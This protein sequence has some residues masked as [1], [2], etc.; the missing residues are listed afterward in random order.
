MLLYQFWKWR[1]QFSFTIR[2]FH[3]RCDG[4]QKIV[5]SHV[6]FSLALG[7]DNLKSGEVAEHFVTVDNKFGNISFV[8]EISTRSL[9]HLLNNF[10]YFGIETEDFEII[11]NSIYWR[12]FLITNN[13]LKVKLTALNTASYGFHIPLFFSP[14]SR[15]FSSSGKISVHCLLEHL[16]LARHLLCFQLFLPAMQLQHLDFWKGIWCSWK[17]IWSCSI[18]CQR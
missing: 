1:E 6:N 2:L 7:I 13:R 9:K 5:R 4:S 3:S 12:T 15:L 18:C 10:G 14:W 11:Y 8:I 16:Q 17:G